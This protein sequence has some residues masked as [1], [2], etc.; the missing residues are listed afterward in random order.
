MPVDVFLTGPYL[1]RADVLL[2]RKNRDFRSWLVR[3]ASKGS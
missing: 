3:F 1:Q 2:T